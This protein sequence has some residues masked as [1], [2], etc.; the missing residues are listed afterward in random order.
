MG[1]LQE[2]MVING[3]RVTFL[4]NRDNPQYIVHEAF[5]AT[6]THEIRFTLQAI[7]KSRG[8]EFL[9]KHYNYSCPQKLQYNIWADAL[10]RYRHHPRDNDL[11]VFKNKYSL[12]KKFIFALRAWCV[13]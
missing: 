9:I 8:Y 5:Y 13:L 10:W 6:N 12:F 3:Y 1:E 4:Y 11:I 7:W 2:T